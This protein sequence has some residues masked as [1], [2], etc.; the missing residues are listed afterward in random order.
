MVFNAYYRTPLG[1][2]EFWVTSP[3]ISASSSWTHATW[4]TPAVPAGS[5]ALSFGLAPDSDGTLATTRYSLVRAR[6]SRTRL[7]AVSAVAGAL[8]IAAVAFG[9]HRRRRRLEL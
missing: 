1:T 6:S 9:R 4:T 7:V 5:S 3:P 8:L 2:W